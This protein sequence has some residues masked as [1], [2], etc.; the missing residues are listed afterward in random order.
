MSRRRQSHI[1]WEPPKGG[2]SR[3]TAK[4]RRRREI[5][6]RRARR[7]EMSMTVSKPRKF[8]AHRAAMA[9]PKVVAAIAPTDIQYVSLYY[10]GEGGQAQLAIPLHYTMVEPDE[11]AIALPANLTHCCP[12]PSRCP[13]SAWECNEYEY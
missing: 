2:A 12:D 11:K 7:K 5:E 13:L 3:T 6:K 1:N 4:Q 10:T 9:Q 8:H